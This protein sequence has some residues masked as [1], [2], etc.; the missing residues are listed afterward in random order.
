M[1]QI[2]SLFNS[3]QIAQLL[4]LFNIKSPG[5]VNDFTEKFND[6]ASMGLINTEELVD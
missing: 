5:N 3:L 4:R 6:I 2:W 1:D